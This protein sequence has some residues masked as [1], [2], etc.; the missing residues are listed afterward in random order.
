MKNLEAKSNLAKSNLYAYVMISMTYH[1][2]KK[3]LIEQGLSDSVPICDD[4][5]V[6]AIRKSQESGSFFSGVLD[7]LTV[8]QVWTLVREVW[9]Q[10]YEK[11]DERCKTQSTI[12][13]SDVISK[14]AS[15]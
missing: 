1:K 3:L 6:A 14:V 12:N 15:N 4:L 9:W 5:A 11:P 2:E 8:D 7:S 13:I 10:H